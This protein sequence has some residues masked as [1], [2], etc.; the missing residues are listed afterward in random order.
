MFLYTNDKKYL[1]KKII[2]F[3]IASETT[4][5]LEINLTKEVKYLYAETYKMPVK[6]IEKDN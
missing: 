5:Y 6:E 2:P 3:A 4:K 1:K